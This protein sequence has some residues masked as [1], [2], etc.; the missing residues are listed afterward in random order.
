MTPLSRYRRGLAEKVMGW[1]SLGDKWASGHTHVDRHIRKSSW[2]PDEDVAQAIQ[3]L[4]ASKWS[5]KLQ[6]AHTGYVC[7]LV[8]AKLQ[9]VFKAADTL[10][11]AICL[12]VIAALGLEPSE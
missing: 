4:E 7:D 8:N 5:W 9:H 3:V 2:R 11:A 10:P 6:P 12:A 1:N